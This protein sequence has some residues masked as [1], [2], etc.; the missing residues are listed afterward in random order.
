MKSNNLLKQV[1]FLAL[2]LTSFASFSQGTATLKGQVTDETGEPIFDATI[3]VANTQIGAKSDFDGNFELTG[4]PVEGEK[5]LVTIILRGIGFDEKSFEIEF[6]PGQTVTKDLNAGDNILNMDE[7]VV[8]GY[9]TTR[10]KDITGAATK[11]TSEDFNKTPVANPEQLIQGKVAGVKITSNDGAP[12]SGS[13]IRLR[14]G[15]S[16]NA[17]NDPLIV[18][19]GVPLDNGGIAGAPS[20]L[21]LINPND[22]ASFVILKDASAT[23]IYGSRGANGVILITTKTGKGGNLDKVRINFTASSTVSTIARYAEV[24]NADQFRELVNLYGT[25]AQI[26]LL[27]DANTD[28]QREIYRTGLVQDYNLSVSGGIKALPYR[29]SIGARLEDGVLKR[30]ELNRYNVGLNLN[31]SFLDNHLML[32]VQTKYARTYAF[33]ANRGAIGA[34]NSFDPTKPITTDSDLYGGYYEW[35]QANGDPQTLAPKNPVGLLNQREDFGNVDRLIGNAK[36]TYKFHF[37]PQMRATVNA[38]TDISVGQGETRV[39][40]TSASGF[41][42]DGSFNEYRSTKRNKLL[43]A[44]VNYNS[45]TLVKDWLFDATLGYAYQD[46]ETSTPAFATFNFDGDSIINP[47]DP[48]P[49]YT[50]NALLSFYG[51]GIV[52]Y[53][54]RYV[55]TATLRRDGSSRFSPETRWGLFPSL[56]AAWIINEESFMKDFKKLNLL[57]LRA[58]YGVTGQQDIGADYPYIPNYQQGTLTAQYYFGGTYYTVLRPDGYDAGI[59]WEETQSYNV[60]LDFGFL[61]DRVSGTIDWYYKRT[62]DLLAVVPVMA[63]TNFTNQILTNVGSMQNTGIEIAV[64]GA[65]MVKKDFRWEIGANFTYNVN[66]VLNLTQVADT[67]SPGIP[68]GG[69]AGGIGN[70]VQIHS[71]G[72]PTF[73]FYVYE[74]QYDAAGQP[75][76]VGADNGAGGT[77]TE[78]EAFV[79]RNEDGVINVEDLYRFEQAAPDAFIGLNMNFEYK[80][81]FAGFSMRSELGGYI[82][83]NVHSNNGTF[84]NVGTLGF[85]NNLSSTFYQEEFQTSTDK[86]LLSDHYLEKADFLRLDYLNIGYRFKKYLTL[87][88]TVNNAFILTNYTGIDPEINGGIDNSIY[89]RPRF[90][91]VNLSFNL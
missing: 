73:S 74:Q 68:V 41:F 21:S 32:D 31:P 65:A 44:Y 62:D 43:E 59:K 39:P 22:I 2:I 56:S 14:G 57:K 19:D 85:L 4:I 38:G 58:G 87:S 36:L 35:T 78:T 72:F 15:T 9:G 88:F 91:T 67:T 18:V 64:N 13:T 66:E 34:A 11:I 83:N 23:A 82:Y 7:V 53:K 86:Q 47:A 51:R 26:D 90:Y 49:F 45:D 46:W 48:N 69:I 27:G 76:E 70:N 61:K 52:N 63:G 1:L 29:F 42:S 80:R 3:L 81:W 33:Y 75:I 71:V 5:Q 54:E 16:I 6:M 17:S 89:P 10:T 28:W 30:D 79:D 84:Q 50:A 40:A 25:Q 20:A 12:G 24:L 37:L 60:G 55:L 77:Y 8:V